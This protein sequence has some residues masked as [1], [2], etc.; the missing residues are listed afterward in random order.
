[1]IARTQLAVLHFNSCINA[2]QALTQKKNEPRY[3]LQFSK[4]TQCFVVKQ[5]KRRAKKKFVDDSRSNLLQTLLTG[6]RYTLPEVPLVKNGREK[7]D[8]Q[9]T[10]Q[11][12]CSRFAIPS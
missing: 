1:M 9:V 5:I 4:V 6:T 12:R 10:I 7:P 11:Q 8:K 3:K 2:E